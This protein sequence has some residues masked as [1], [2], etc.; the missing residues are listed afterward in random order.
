VKAAEVREVVL[1]DTLLSQVKALISKASGIL[2]RAEASGDDRCALQA[3]REVRETLHLLGKITGEIEPERAAPRL[4]PMFILPESA[5]L[6]F[7]FNQQNNLIQPPRE[8][9]TSKFPAKLP[10]GSEASADPGED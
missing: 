5:N 2:A 3:C 10:L 6:S 7:S 9:S 8:V 4:T 1:A